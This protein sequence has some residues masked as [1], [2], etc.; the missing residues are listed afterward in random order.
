[1]PDTFDSQIRPFPVPALLEGAGPLEGMLPHLHRIR[2][3]VQAGRQPG[4]AT[5]LAGFDHA[6]GGLQKGVHLLAAEPGA[7][8]T[9]LALQIARKAASD[10]VSVVYLAF[11][12]SGDRLALKLASAAA[13]LIPTDFLRGKADP[14]QVVQALEAHRDVLA[15]IRIYTGPADIDT[16]SCAA[17]LAEAMQIDGGTEGLLVVDYVQSWAARL[18]SASDFRV[19]VTHLVGGLRQAALASGVPVLA[20]AAQNRSG[21]GEAAMKSLRESSD[22]EY[23]ADS[24]SFL[25]A[26]D[27]AMVGT[28]ARRRVTLSCKKNRSGPTFDVSLIFD[29]EKSLFTEDRRPR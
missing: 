2:A 14:E 20:I 28:Q 25:V 10:G 11:D 4:I 6:T 23:T 27:Q 8:K 12:E 7:G 17:M 29:A 15:R 13:G 24:I 19:A 16:D 26:D 21:Q 9:T 1:M 22:L 5:G 3:R 18:K